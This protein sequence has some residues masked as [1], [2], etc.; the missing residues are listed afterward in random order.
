MATIFRYTTGDER[1]YLQEI[2]ISCRVLWRKGQ[3]ISN[4]TVADL[5]PPGVQNV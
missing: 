3:S 1:Y 4:L 5:L 2:L